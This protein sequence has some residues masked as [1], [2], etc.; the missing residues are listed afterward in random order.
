MFNDRKLKLGTFCTNLSGGCTMSSIDG[1]LQAKWDSV[2]TLARMADEMEFE[3]IVPI[4]RWKCFG[5]VPAPRPRGGS[6]PR[7][8]PMST[9]SISMRILSTRRELAS[10]PRAR[11]RGTNASGK[12]KFGQ[13]PTSFR[14]TPKPK[15][16]PSTGILYS[17]NGDWE[18]VENLVSDWD[19]T[20]LLPTD[21]Y[22][23]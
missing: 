13:T 6:S 18:S 17:K 8:L 14:L 5:G 7:S 11:R 4:G 1:V 9:S 16:A 19:E 10:T 12:S 23:S 20:V 21:V 15:R 22:R 2:L 3:A